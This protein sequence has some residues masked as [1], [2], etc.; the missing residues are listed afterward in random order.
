MGSIANTIQSFTRTLK[1]IL[2]GKKYQ[3]DYFQREYKWET[4]HMEQL[5]LD[6]EASFLSNYE[7]H[8]IP[9]EVANY[10]SYYLGPIV[11]SEKDNTK[12]I[13]DGQQ[14]LTSLTLLLIY[15][16]NKQKD[17]V[18]KEELESLIYSK[19]HSRK[20]YN[21]EVPDRSKVLDAL[22]LNGDVDQ[23]ELSDESVQNMVDRYKDIG[24]FFP[25]AL[26]NEKLLLMFIDWLKEK[27]VFVEIVAFS[28]EN[29]YTIFETMNDRGLN[30]T[31]TEMLKSYVLTNVKDSDKIY[32]LNQ[33]WKIRIS[34]LHGISTQE[35]LEFMRAWLRG[36][37]ADTIRSRTKGSGNED[38]EKIGTRFHTWIKDNH[39][40]IGLKSSE[41]FYHFIKSDFDFYSKLYIRIVSGLRG[42]DQSIKE[43]YFSSFWSIATSLSY[44]LFLSPISKLDDEKTI[45]NKIICI[46]KFIDLYS[47]YRT[48]SDKPITQSA[49]RYSIYSLVK[50]IRNKELI[51]LKEIL[52]DELLSS[53]EIHPDLQSFNATFANDKFIRYIL[54]RITFHIEREYF[55][56]GIDFYDLIVSRKKNR[57]VVSP[58]I[59]RYTFDD[60]KHIFSSEEEYNRTFSQLGNYILIPNPVHLSI[61]DVPDESKLQ[62]L[63][64]E[65]YL[66]S[67]RAQSSNREINLKF[68]IET[69]NSFS[70]AQISSRTVM[71]QKVIGE[72]WNVDDI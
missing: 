17:F 48:L 6:L 57:Y 47:V 27:I 41:S 1:E 12:S 14:R 16:N 2:D 11:L 64:D 24:D 10:N 32:E 72:I 26:N 54:A 49:I 59:W 63:E 70:S 22:F 30:L 45:T 21:I 56:S 18:E 50:R 67:C 60:Y 33:L 35:D 34:E 31:P 61:A 25:E 9:E 42:D 29:A 55:K 3:V 19:K 66:S 13:V 40:S 46:G 38:F 5:L 68:G 7:Y 43:L 71:L 37:Y 65:N 52:R 23:D 8:H 36:Q 28:D 4:K 44:P 15:L 53:T 39:K 51:E 20:S 62:F 58:L 69:I